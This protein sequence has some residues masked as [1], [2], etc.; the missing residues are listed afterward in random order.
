M[1]TTSEQLLQKLLQQERLAA[2]STSEHVSLANVSRPSDFMTTTP[3]RSPSAPELRRSQ[4]ISLDICI[5]K[6]AEY[7]YDD[8]HTNPARNKTIAATIAKLRL[9]Q[10]NNTTSSLEIAAIL[11]AALNHE[12]MQDAGDGK[13]LLEQLL[14]GVQLSSFEST[15][16]VPETLEKIKHTAV[17]Q[18]LV[19]YL[20][21]PKQDN[22]TENKAIIGILLHLVEFK[23]I[24]LDQ[25]TSL[26]RKGI[27]IFQ[28]EASSILGRIK[29]PSTGLA[30]LEELVLSLYAEDPFKLI[31]QLTLAQCYKLIDKTPSPALNGLLALIL[32]S[33]SAN[34]DADSLFFTFITHF[35][36]AYR[37]SIDTSTEKGAVESHLLHQSVKKVFGGV[38]INFKDGE[39][40]IEKLN[41]FINKLFQLN[42]NKYNKLSSYLS[43]FMKHKLNIPNL[44]A[45]AFIAHADVSC[46]EILHSSQELRDKKIPAIQASLGK[47]L[48]SCAKVKAKVDGCVKEINTL[49]EGLKPVIAR[50]DEINTKLTTING[51]IEQ[52]EKDIAKAE[53]AKLIATNSKNNAVKF[54]KKKIQALKDSITLLSALLAVSS[55]AAQQKALNGQI[56]KTQKRIE[57]SENNLKSIEIEFRDCQSR[58]ATQEKHLQAHITDAKTEKEKLTAEHAQ[59]ESE[60]KTQSDL[61][62]KLQAQHD[63]I[64]TIYEKT[65]KEVL[66]QQAALTKAQEKL[67]EPGSEGSTRINE[68]LSGIQKEIS[69]AKDALNSWAALDHNVDIERKVIGVNVL[70]SE[71]YKT[72]SAMVSNPDT[73][74]RLVACDP[75]TTLLPF[76]YKLIA[77]HYNHSLHTTKIISRFA[78]LDSVF[79]TKEAAQHL[80]SRNFIDVTSFK[81]PVGTTP[82][83]LI[84]F[85]LDKFITKLRGDST[86]GQSGSDLD[87][88]VLLSHLEAIRSQW[89]K[90]NPKKQDRN[91]AVAQKHNDAAKVVIDELNQQLVDV[92]AAAQAATAAVEQQH[93]CIETELPALITQLNAEIV[94]AKPGQQHISQAEIRALTP[95]ALR[96][97]QVIEV[98]TLRENSA[99]ILSTIE[100]EATRLL[101]LIEEKSPLVLLSSL[102]E[103]QQTDAQLQSGKIYITQDAVNKSILHYAVKSVTGITRGQVSVALKKSLS[104]NGLNKH[105][106][107]ILAK[108]P[109]NILNIVARDTGHYTVTQ[110]TNINIAHFNQFIATLQQW[111]DDFSILPDKAT[112]VS[113]LDSMI[114]EL[115]AK[116]EAYES[117]QATSTDSTLTKAIDD[118]KARL[119]E[120]KT[121]LDGLQPKIRQ[122]RAEIADAQKENRSL[123]IAT[124]ETRKDLG[125]HAEK[126]HSILAPLV[127]ENLDNARGTSALTGSARQSGQDMQAESAVLSN[128]IDQAR[129][130]VREQKTLKDKFIALAEHDFT[131]AKTML[132][133]AIREAHTYLSNRDENKLAWASGKQCA[134]KQEAFLALIKEVEN[135]STSAKLVAVYSKTFDEAKRRRGFLANFD[136]FRN[137]ENAESIKILDTHLNS[138]IKAYMERDEPQR[139]ALVEVNLSGTRITPIGR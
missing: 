100:K 79:H 99:T 68:K 18:A 19:N 116:K 52:I 54:A 94:A 125:K 109:D 75:A 58:M 92:D 128:A 3:S 124:D 81:E 71:S 115:Q 104:E 65:Q 98:K 119:T 101:N 28:N 55:D 113:E 139:D 8:K 41:L 33:D 27:G 118:Y 56:K 72:L 126:S 134:E 117:G 59:V 105:R 111:R 83:E 133:A 93:T 108:I 91:L 42:N 12:S 51:N 11:V 60:F 138:A 66:A 85:D 44:T 110:E 74:S 39:D 14:R 57:A 34:K 45:E 46:Q 67:T 120:L 32:K 53:K 31:E 20:D 78:L 9:A 40:N 4:G 10:L 29:G 62:D 86:P 43:L 5:N 76:I 23:D 15:P 63:A 127:A 70:D 13:A 102:P 73:L 36:D 48:T 69:A 97:T 88:N 129:A 103:P 49:K 130:A 37:N 107:D 1:G 89:L 26:L 2:R 21:D 96:T 7:L 35:I 24:P 131:E 122:A 135:I 123:K 50:R 25:L 61:L 80:F 95:P 106:F 16:A 82:D 6:L 30:M 38:Y 17:I 132:L 114:S 90:M 84:R 136:S 137:D 87:S 64:R 77:A 112:I 121:I 47:Q 22:V